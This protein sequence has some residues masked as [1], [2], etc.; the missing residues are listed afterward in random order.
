MVM[1]YR[2]VIENGRVADA[3]VEVIGRSVV[4]HSRGGATSGRA[5]RNT[6]YAEA[7]ITICR[8]ARAGP[9]ALER[10]LIDSSVARRQSET[11]RVLIEGGEI[12]ALDGEDLA[13][14]IRVRARRFG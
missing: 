1:S 7:L 11:E 4:L 10:V 9:A 14:A 12:N 13:K 3:R 2:I 6:G 5:A 8:R